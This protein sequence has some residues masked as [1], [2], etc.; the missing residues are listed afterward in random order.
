MGEMLANFIA[1]HKFFFAQDV[2]VCV[3][4]EAVS[5][6]QFFLGLMNNNDT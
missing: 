1:G 5:H 4:V 6:L 2:C 3:G